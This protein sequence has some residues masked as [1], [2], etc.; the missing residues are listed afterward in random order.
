MA[1]RDSTQPTTPKQFMTA[2][3]VATHAGYRLEELTALFCAIQELAEPDTF[4][5]TLAGV[6]LDLASLSSVEMS[7]IGERLQRESV[8]SAA[9]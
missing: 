9:F 8:T 6:G 1:D 7:D 4:T 5:R 2:Q 3:D